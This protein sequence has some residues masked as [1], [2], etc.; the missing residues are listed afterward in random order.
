MD[1]VTYYIYRGTKNDV[2]WDCHSVR[3]VRDMMDKFTIMKSDVATS[4]DVYMKVGE[5]KQVP[6]T[7]DSTL[8]CG[9]CYIIRD[10]MKK[11]KYV[12]VFIYTRVV[13]HIFLQK[14]LT[15]TVSFTIKDQKVSKTP[16]TG[17]MYSILSRN[18]KK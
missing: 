15:L 9:G 5:N 16:G 3:K 12:S 8:T 11:R 4:F 6:V 10:K 18:L 7:L 2:S 13:A 17:T 14:S 1:L